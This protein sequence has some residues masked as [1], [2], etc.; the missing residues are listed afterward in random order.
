[1]RRVNK[2]VRRDNAEAPAHHFELIYAVENR[3]L[4]GVEGEVESSKGEDGADDNAAVGMGNGRRG[5]FWGQ[6]IHAQ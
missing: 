1:M 5:D 4:H 2:D 3:H 6:N